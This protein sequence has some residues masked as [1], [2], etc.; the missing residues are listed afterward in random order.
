MMGASATALSELIDTPIDISTPIAEVHDA[1]K[2]FAFEEE[3]VE[4]YVCQ[5]KFNIT[6]D[7]VI[8]SEFITVMTIDLAKAMA[9]KMLEGY[10]TALDNTPSDS[11]ANEV[12]KKIPTESS[13]RSR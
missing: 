5:V 13:L 11:I 3:D 6:I 2:S 1:S 10:G 8:N 12:E 9:D 4:K 7:G